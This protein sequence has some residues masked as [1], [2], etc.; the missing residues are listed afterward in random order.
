MASTKPPGWGDDELSKFLE[1]AHQNQYATF[2]NKRE[3]VAKLVAI[4]AQFSKAT[5]DWLNPENEILAMLFIRCIGAYRTACGLA[6]SGQAAECYVQSRS[7]LEYAAYAV[8]IN[9]DRSLGKVWLDRHEDEAGMKASKNAFQHAKVLK[10]LTSAN[11]HAAGRFET[12][13]QRTIDFGGHPN[14]RAVTANLKIVEEA[15]RRKMLGILQHGD[16][17]QLEMAL[18]TTAQCGLISLELLETIYGPKF[19]LL[20]IKAAMLDLRRTGL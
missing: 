9:K 19:E 11:R 8:H 10:S 7:V 14:E 15:D 20:G 17:V 1:A 2:V 3:A 4:D 12:I 13:Y 16:G 5:K 6:M 18:K